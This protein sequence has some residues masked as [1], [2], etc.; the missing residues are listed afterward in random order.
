MVKHNSSNSDY[1]RQILAVEGVSLTKGDLVKP[2]QK[3]KFLEIMDKYAGMLPKSSTPLR[4]V[5][6][7]LE[8]GEEFK[9]RLEKY[10]RPMLIKGV[11][12]LINELRILYKQEG[13]SEII[14]TLLQ[15]LCE[16]M[17]ND[18]VL[19]KDDDQE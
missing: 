6:E 13:K 15:E 14:G 10:L 7:H 12:S 5:I 3:A 11:P 8:A 1:F 17:E 2:E 19:R 16:N 4:L 9:T 18:M